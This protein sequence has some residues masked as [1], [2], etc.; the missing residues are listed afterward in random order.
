M[1]RLKTIIASKL[2]DKEVIGINGKKI[3]NLFDI[4]TKEEDG[5][6]LG[7]IIT[8]KNEEIEKFF[9]TDKEGKIIVPYSAISSFSE[10]VVVD[11]R[12]LPRRIKKYQ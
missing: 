6:I 11:E 1:F 4:S 8:P 7:I 3:G 5:S 9:Q 10:L 2:R 12:R